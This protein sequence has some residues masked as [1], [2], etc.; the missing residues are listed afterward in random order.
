M[1]RTGVPTKGL[2]G[3]KAGFEEA[4]V[5]EV[6]RRFLVGEDE[7]RRRAILRLRDVVNAHG[8]GLRV[9]RAAGRLLP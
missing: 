5:A 8:R 1:K 2:L 4:L 9:V 3:A 7:E 6:Q